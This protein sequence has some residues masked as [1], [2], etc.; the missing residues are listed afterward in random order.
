MQLP[1]EVGL[2]HPKVQELDLLV[3]SR[4]PLHSQ[5]LPWDWT[6]NLK[7]LRNSN[8][9]NVLLKLNNLDLLNFIFLFGLNIL[10]T[11]K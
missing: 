11:T 9:L 5:P 3:T 7:F 2:D 8:A 6:E 4:N 1:W 10:I